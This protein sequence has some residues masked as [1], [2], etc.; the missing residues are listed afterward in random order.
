MSCRTLT[1]WA[2]GDRRG[3]RGHGGSR[4]WCRW[5]VTHLPPLENPE[6]RV[7]NIPLHSTL[8]EGWSERSGCIHSPI[9]H[10]VLAGLLVICK[11]VFHP[12]LL[13][14]DT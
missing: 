9:S 7:L 14:D 4:A 1:P 3:A 11:P 8:G 5:E 13:P 6:F 12:I 2:G 10:Q